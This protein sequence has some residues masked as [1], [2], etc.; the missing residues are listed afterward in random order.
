MFT[1]GFIANDIG[2]RVMLA[3]PPAVPVELAT[4]VPVIAAHSV[5]GADASTVM[6]R[7]SPADSR[8]QCAASG[9][10][11]RVV[12]VTGAV[13]AGRL[14]NPPEPNQMQPPATGSAV[15][16][17]VVR[18]GLSPSSVDSFRAVADSWGPPG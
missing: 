16:S 4:S 7:R 6:V 3:W 1:G 2:T 8:R 9:A 11:G 13:P 10:A 17:K 12:S 14:G 15:T 18:A 5:C